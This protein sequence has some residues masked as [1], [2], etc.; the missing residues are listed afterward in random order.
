M[1]GLQPVVRP[2]AMKEKTRLPIK[3][4]YYLLQLKRLEKGKNVIN[5]M[6]VADDELLSYTVYS[7]KTSV[8]RQS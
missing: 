1:L 7:S 2:W 5:F 3:I 4:L 6:Q 8:E